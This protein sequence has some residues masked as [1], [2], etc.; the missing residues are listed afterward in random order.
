[1]CA[2][3]TFKFWKTASPTVVGIVLRAR[4]SRGSLMYYNMLRA[5]LR[6]M[7]PSSPRRALPLLM[8]SRSSEQS[9][10]IINAREMMMILHYSDFYYYSGDVPYGS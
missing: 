5:R 4:H 6:D 10:F 9:T 8:K 7:P 2:R 3:V 1:M